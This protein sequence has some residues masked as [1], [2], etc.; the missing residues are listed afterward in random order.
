[1]LPQRFR[2]IPFLRREHVET[3]AGVTPC[4]P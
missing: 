1:L 2:I 3:C 4:A